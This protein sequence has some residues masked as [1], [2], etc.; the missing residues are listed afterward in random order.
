MSEVFGLPDRMKRYEAVSDSVLVRRSPVIVRV[1]GKSFHTLTRGMDRPFD[2]GL[3]ACMDEVA[4]SLC[5]HT[6]GA[7]LAYIQSDEVSV[8][9]VDYDTLKTEGWFGYRVQKMASV[10]ASIATSNFDWAFRNEFPD[11][12]PGGLFDARVFVLPRDEV[13]NYFVWRQRD[14]VRNSIQATGQAHFSPKQ[15]HGKSLNQ[16]QEMLFQEHGINWN[17]T[18][19][20]FK[21]GR[22]V[23]RVDREW[24]VDRHTPEFTE[25]RDYIEGRMPVAEE[26]S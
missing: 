15:L 22:C 11:R 19:N 16:I 18:P 9:L 12:T 6:Q 14:A 4:L 13:V 21:R 3:A 26:D 7:K 5:D 20:D 25:D 23:I 24:E 17:D 8:V 10:A 1:D 2:T